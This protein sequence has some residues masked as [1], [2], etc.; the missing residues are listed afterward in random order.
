MTTLPLRFAD[1]EVQDEARFGGKSASLA[2]ATAD[3]LLVPPGFGLAVDLVHAVAAN[4]PAAHELIAS[5]VDEIGPA[6]AVRSSA[7][8]EDGAA[9][10]F[11]GQH[12]TVQNVT[13]TEGLI[14]AICEVHA[15]ATSDAA[16]AY[17]QQMKIEGEPRIAVAVQRQVASDV[18]GVMF[19]RHPITGDAE[20]Y[21]ECA[22]GLGEAIVAGLVVPDTFRLS[23]AGEVLER[24][25]GFKELKLV[26]SGDGEIAEVPVPPAS[27]EALCL[28]DAQL[29]SLWQL[30]DRCGQV[31]GEGL[32]IEWCVADGTI[33]LLQCR[34]I[35]I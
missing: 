19:T 24:T 34:G 14:S 33:Y 30:G 28:T 4:T 12:L 15:S 13:S 29:A 9:A 16:L 17:R 11:A 5:L 20:Y 1:A 31:Y 25:P 26:A 3:G 7:V 2:R 21:V 23:S 27:V 22:W 18:A 35:T 32:D 8:G 10:S 6:V